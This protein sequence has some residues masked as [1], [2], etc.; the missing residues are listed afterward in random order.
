MST[1]LSER[2]PPSREKAACTKE[3]QILNEHGERKQVDPHSRYPK[4]KKGGSRELHFK[5][6][7]EKR[8]GND[9][10]TRKRNATPVP[11]NYDKGWLEMKES[12]AG[13]LIIRGTG[14]GLGK[15]DES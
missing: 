15:R 3:R 13:A 6:W 11:G 7:R 10:T 5:V 12:G 14:G 9:I 2:T 4:R 8:G 1:S